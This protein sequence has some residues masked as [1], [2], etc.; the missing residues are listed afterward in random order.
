[1]SDLGDKLGNLMYRL[2]DELKYLRTAA[3]EKIDRAAESMNNL[4]DRLGNDSEDT[5]R[6][7]PA[8]PVVGRIREITTKQ[9]YLGGTATFLVEY[10]CGSC[11]A[12]RTT[13]E[14]AI[15]QN[16][17]VHLAPVCGNCH[18]RNRLRGLKIHL[19]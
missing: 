12:E 1:M 6:A 5:S 16:R 7:N 10:S 3:T 11:G 18:T 14:Y 8:E 17:M 2:G 4:V 9:P 19:K 13:E 15:E